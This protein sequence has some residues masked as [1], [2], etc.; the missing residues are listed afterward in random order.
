MVHGS[1][2]PAN[3]EVICDSWQDCH[4]KFSGMGD[5]IHSQGVNSNLF[6]QHLGFEKGQLFNQR[7]YL[8]GEVTL[9]VKFSLFN[10]KCFTSTHHLFPSELFGFLG[11]NN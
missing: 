7:D 10:F 6:K 8:H 11:H 3:L 1:F 9:D 2:P 4:L 5:E